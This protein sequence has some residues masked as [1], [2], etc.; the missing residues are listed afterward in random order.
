MKEPDLELYV[1]SARKT[2]VE[3]QVL[4]QEASMR[5]SGAKGCLF[6]WQQDISRMKFMLGCLKSQAQ[7]LYQCI[8][9]FEIGENLIKN[10]WSQGLLVQLIGRMKHWQDQLGDRLDRLDHIDN[11]L[12]ETEVDGGS[13]RLGDFIP[14]ENAHILDERLKEIPIIRRQ[15]DNIRSQYADMTRKVQDQLLETKMKNLESLFEKNFG[16]SSIESIELSETY[17]TEMT[18]LEHELVEYLNSLTDH[19]DKCKLLQENDLQGQNRQELLEIVTRDHGELNSVLVTLRDTIKDVDELLVK[20]KSNLDKNMI[21]GN[22]I[23]SEMNKIINDFHKYQEYLTIFKDISELITTF[24]ETCLQEIQVAQELCDF[25]ENFEA[26]YYKLLEEAKRRHSV[27][28]E[29]ANVLREA[30]G[31]L[32]N[33]HQQDHEI[34]KKFLAENGNFLPETIWP[35]KIDDFAPL[36]S[37][38]YTIKDI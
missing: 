10:E 27:A 12:V 5:I 2:L 14:K 37:L 35:G 25:Y 4:C 34:R 9:K 29:M 28:Q 6:E 26:S 13:V 30:E 24:R 32:Q 8:L 16:S 33:L 20:F 31:K 19:F 22:Q 21:S 7:F 17:L 3:A 36:Y 15:I 11:E 23:R 18:N 38:Q 1:S